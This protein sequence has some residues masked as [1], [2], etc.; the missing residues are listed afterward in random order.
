[1]SV[2]DETN[3]SLRDKIISLT[4]IDNMTSKEAAKYLG[5]SQDMVEKHL[6]GY[7]K[8]VSAQANGKT[9]KTYN[10]YS[11]DVKQKVLNAYIEEHKTPKELCENFKISKSTVY[12]WLKDYRKQNNLP[13]ANPR[14]YP[15]ELIQEVLAEKYINRVS[16][17]ELSAKYN[18]SIHTIYYWMKQYGKQIKSKL[19]IDMDKKK[20]KRKAPKLYTQEVKLNVVKQHLIENISIKELANMYNV[21]TH[22]IYSWVKDNKETVL[23]QNKILESTETNTVSGSEEVLEPITDDLVNSVENQETAPED[24]IESTLI[25]YLQNEISRLKSENTR[26][27]QALSILANI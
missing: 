23:Q 26:L 18:L 21:T 10:S 15:T 8:E 2:L 19:E 13:L 11:D 14:Y 25:N 24:S 6:K 5:I 4:A 7:Y 27:R 16:A 9:S 3:N 22:T 1:M 12:N 17:K 20:K